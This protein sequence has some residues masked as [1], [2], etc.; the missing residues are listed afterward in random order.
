MVTGSFPLD[1]IGYHLYVAQGSESP[2]SELRAQILA[3]LADVH[4]VVTAHE[5][6]SSSKQL[7]VSEYGFQASAVG[8]AGQAERMAAAFDAMAEAGTVA[9]A[10]Y[11]NLRDFPGSTWGIIDD[12]GATRPGVQQLASISAA[13][14]PALG[15]QALAAFTAPLTA[16]EL[17]TV[18]VTLENRGASTWTD[19]VRLAAAPGCPDARAANAI[20]WEPA[21][22]YANGITDARV[23]L[24]APVP[25][26]GSVTL[27]VPVRAPSEPG[28]YTFAARLVREGVSWFGA[29]ATANV[30][31]TA[32]PGSGEDPAGSEQD[33]DSERS[34]CTA[35][36]GGGIPLALA[37]LLRRRRHSCGMEAVQQRDSD[38]M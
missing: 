29:T 36:T 27:E 3:N 6:A 24:A 28:S 16:G 18:T 32:K 13:H 5:G 8:P 2:L 26:G 19:E 14:R 37:L 25:P 15:A 7:W 34:G 1:G 17:G 20:A 35:A 4:S 23:F 38:R 33:P 11:F 21:N 30:V 31:V 12:T 22:G 10:L 9:I